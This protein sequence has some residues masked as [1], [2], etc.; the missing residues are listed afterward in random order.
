LG[1]WG[2]VESDTIEDRSALKITTVEDIDLFTQSSSEMLE[3]QR[4]IE[5]LLLIKNAKELE[6]KG[7]TITHIRPIESFVEIGIT[8]YTSEN[9]SF[10]FDVVG[11][12][13]VSIIDGGEESLTTDAA[14]LYA[15]DI[16]GKEN[17]LKDLNENNWCRFIVLSLIC[18]AAI[19]M[20]FMIVKKRIWIR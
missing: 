17:D 5:E 6:A 8:P 9:V 14:R 3:K 16:G 11:K 1:I 18:G 12:G 19:W 15:G 20:V 2:I 13:Y 7:L 4:E 10:I